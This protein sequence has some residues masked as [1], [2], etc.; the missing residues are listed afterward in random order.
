MSTE[1]PRPLQRMTPLL[2]D[3]AAAW[4]SSAGRMRVGLTGVLGWGAFVV[5][6]VTVKLLFSILMVSFPILFLLPRR[7]VYVP[8]GALILAVR[9]AV[10]RAILRQKSVRIAAWVR[11]TA[12]AEAQTIDDWTE[13]ASAPEDQLVSVVGWA[14]ARVRFPLPVA[15]EPCIGLALPCQQAYPGVLESLNDF[16][17]VDEAGQSIPIQV[18]GGRMM[19]EANTD[20][21]GGHEQRLLVASLDLPAGAAPAG[22]H[23]FVLRDG[24]P[25]LII[26]F[27]K[28]V[29]DPTEPGLRQT[30]VRAA[31]A[32]NLPRPLLIFPIDAERRVS[33][34]WG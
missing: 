18:A 26:G 24:D 7:L 22:W 34:G 33:S 19:G 3:P 27:K 31:L 9:P 5:S 32:S 29:V 28:S 17:L 2:E 8:L 23:A 11:Q 6:V 4:L 16:D 14:R 25:L 30:P 1:V 20:I 10:R 13:L 15:G 21:G 12:P